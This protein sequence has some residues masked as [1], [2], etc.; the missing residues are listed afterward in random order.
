MSNPTPLPA[1]SSQVDCWSCRI[2]S[3]GGL[4][5]AGGYVYMQAQK[6]KHL[7]G[8]TSMGR[9]AQIM[10]AAGLASWGL[11]VIADPVGKKTRKE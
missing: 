11:V 3:G 1:K 5:A 7:S 9:V 4:L 2:L 8:P 6:L 10:F